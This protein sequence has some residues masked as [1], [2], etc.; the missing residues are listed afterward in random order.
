M[1]IL[2][3]VVAALLAGATA[4][5]QTTTTSGTP[6]PPKAPTALPTPKAEPENPGAYAPPLPREQ[7][8]PTEE[9]VGPVQRHFVRASQLDDVAD[10]EANDNAA[11][12][13][14]QA[15]E[16]I[17]IDRRISVPLI[18]DVQN[19]GGGSEGSNQALQYELTYLNWGAVTQEQLA[20][21]LGHYFTITWKNGGPAA[22]FTAR[23]QY[24]EVKSQEVVR[25]LT[26]PMPH[27]HGA[28]R[29][30][31]A[32]T[33]KAYLAY[34]PVVSWR[35]TILKGDTVVAEEKSSLW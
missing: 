9:D 10:T 23:F 15:R 34:G 2:P 27:V 33:D 22:D 4:S 30:Y 13:A 16:K 17:A 32:V 26:Q 21:R 12:A 6:K 7:E 18:H 35:F 28:V 11:L 29:S 19:G 14:I 5:A 20:A 31:F 3:C 24:R 1:R 25:T 8:G